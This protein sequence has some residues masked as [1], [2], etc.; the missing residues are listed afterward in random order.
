MNGWPDDAGLPG[1]WLAGEGL[2]DAD[3]LFGPDIARPGMR[4]WRTRR[5]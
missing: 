2:P 3:E 1:P 5:R 4:S